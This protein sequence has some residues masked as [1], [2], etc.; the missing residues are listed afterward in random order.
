MSGNNKPVLLFINHWAQNP[1][2]A[3][4]S[5]V[6]IMLFAQKRFDCH[7]V[8]SERG[9]LTEKASAMQVA[10]HVIPCSK[11]LG[12]IRRWR[13]LHTLLFSWFSIPSYIVFVVR[14]RGL[15][16]RLKPAL[17]HANVPKSHIA[18]FLL[19]KC[20]YAGACCFHIREIFER[21]SF[22]QWLYAVLFPR[23]NGFAVAI[24]SAVKSHLPPRM[25]SKAIVLYNGIAIP[26]AVK[27]YSRGLPLKLLYL[28]RIVPWKGCHVLIE[29][30]S[31]AIQKFPSAG[32][33]LSLVGDTRYWPSL[34]RE[35]L[36]KSINAL[37]L[38]SVCH[39]LPHSDEPQRQFLSFDIFC[40]AS[41]NEPFGRSVAE[42]S[43]HGLP[44]IAFDGGGIPEIV[45][46]NES[47]FVVPVNDR[48]GFVKSIGKYIRNPGLVETMG[49]RAR[50]LA[51]IAFDRKKQA[52]LLCDVLYARIC[53]K[54]DKD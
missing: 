31:L 39:L 52:P 11:A 14:L 25:Q 1:G 19:V 26:D 33:S 17:V 13:F 38:Q 41:Y 2:G 3:E 51:Q 16:R 4:Y 10:S 20:G 29:I 45:K 44:V 18:L 8:T 35:E 12:N 54:Q 49:R 27:S 21:G 5:L 9:M 30:L 24:S 6:D 22:A 50:E 15:V 43:A 48:E 46:N 42:A 36:K 47:G 28:G 34:Y 37:N 23:Q 53:S 7:L 32:I 40:N